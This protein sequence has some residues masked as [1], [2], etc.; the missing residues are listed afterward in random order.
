[1]ITKAQAVIGTKV[2]VYV[3][4]EDKCDYFSDLDV[5]VITD[6]PPHSVPA[7]DADAWVNFNGQGNSAVYGDGIWSV[8]LAEMS[9]VEEVKVEK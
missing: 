8:Y 3:A 9:L 4:E 7:D 6:T 2:R 5:G 1:M